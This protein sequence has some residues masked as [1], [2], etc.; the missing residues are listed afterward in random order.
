MFQP[1]PAPYSSEKN[2]GFPWLRLAFGAAGVTLGAI[3]ATNALIAARTP[4]LGPRL[5]GL[6]DRYPGRYGDLAYVV[7]G[8]GSPVLL[9]HGLD[10]GRSMAEWR[11]VFD[12]LADTHTVYAFDFQGY[13]LSDATPEG[14]DAQ[15]FAEQIT[16]FIRDIIGQ[17]T[18]V[19]AAGQGALLAVL[20]AHQGARISRLALVCPQ[21][22]GEAQPD[23]DSRAE[24]LLQRAVSGSVLS[25][26]FI[27]KAVLNM[28]RSQEQMRKRAYDHGFF[29]K[30]LIPNESRLWYVTAHQ[31][32]AEVSQK[33]LLQGRFAREWQSAW[34]DLS[35]PGLLLWGRNASREG[36]EASS[37]WL[38]L[39]PDARLEVVEQ[40]M[41]FPHLEQPQA[42]C[43]VVLPWLGQA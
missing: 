35:V 15:H 28:W 17:E 10:A 33:S 12:R 3:A 41:L 36:L 25:L 42:F 43:D 8:S 19:L 16:H 38:A 2:T 22:W 11:A 6:F 24:V 30:T 14:Y 37:E 21:E 7:A 34:R 20:A 27:G 4:K 23:G 9:I 13:G 31:P 32:G 29:D 18:A 39:R 26:P 5:S 40:A 1:S